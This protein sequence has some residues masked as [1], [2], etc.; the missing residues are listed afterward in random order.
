M[1]K[2]TVIGGG[3][4]GH[5]LAADLSRRG[6]EVS[7]CEEP[8][9]VDSLKSASESGS[10]EVSGALQEGFVPLERVARDFD[11]A[12]SEADVILV[13]VI[14]N[15]HQS[16]ARRIQPL[17]HDGQSILIGPD[18]GGSLVFAREFRELK[19]VH[20][21][22][23]GG[24]GGNYY[25]CRLVGPAR[26]YVGMPRGPKKVAAFPASDTDDLIESLNGLFE[27]TR[28]ANVL[29]MALSTPN[30]PNHLAGAILNAG[31]IESMDGS[32]NLFRHGLTPS[33]LRSIDSVAA[34]RNAV[35]RA[36]GYDEIHSSVL[37]KVAQLDQHPE[38]DMFRD[39][40]GPSDLR[41]RYVTEDA[42]IGMSLLVSLGH[43]MGV[44]TPVSA[45]LVS[46][47]SAIKDTDYLAAGRTVARIGRDGM[48][49]GE[50]NAYLQTGSTSK[51][52]SG[53]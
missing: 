36:L 4:T 15:R 21:V 13:A 42:E 37:A 40:A 44:D 48:S 6:Y 19:S 20:D 8:A 29:E 9:Y 23:L 10:I 1:K 16:L 53:E 25:A 34:E 11:K 31:V 24:M 28:G 52:G 26:V 22:L 49:T 3:G 50:I 51:P 45:G 32:F 7:L 33:V 2:I 38:L 17:L 30:I 5:T 43:L 47:A 35:L 18:N 14:A 39:L 46:L 12:V 41:H 27:F